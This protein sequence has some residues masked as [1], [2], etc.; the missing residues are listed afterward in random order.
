MLSGAR[1]DVAA[2]K[3]GTERLAALRKSYEEVRDSIP[4]WPIEIMQM[5]GLVTLLILP[6]LL[7]LLP[8]L[9]GLFT[10]K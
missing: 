10:Q 8:L 6:V 3:E 9:L 5:R 7:T 4:T 2:I 1:G